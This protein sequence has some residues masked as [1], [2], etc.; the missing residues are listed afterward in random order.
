[1]T[2][3]QTS[4]E[5]KEAGVESIKRAVGAVILG[6]P[7]RHAKELRLLELSVMSV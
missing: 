3:L 5:V 2:R 1:M 4:Q 6:R 7:V